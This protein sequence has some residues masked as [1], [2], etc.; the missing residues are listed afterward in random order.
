MLKG[1]CH[2]VFDLHFLL[3][4]PICDP[5]KQAKVFLNSVLISPKYLTTNFKKKKSTFYISKLFFHNLKG[6][7]LMVPFKATRDHRNVRFWLCGVQFDSR[8]DAHSRAW[9]H[10]DWL[11]SAV[12]C[13]PQSFLKFDYLGK[14]KEN[15]KI[16]LSGT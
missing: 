16:C 2:D 14:S 9:L 13:T 10:G 3:F 12:W 7:L 8:C 11:R 5:D 15:S 1:V 6:F 4:R